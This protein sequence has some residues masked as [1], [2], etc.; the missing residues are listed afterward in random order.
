MT[1]GDHI[2]QDMAPLLRI[3]SLARRLDYYTGTVYEAALVDFPDDNSV[4]VVGRYKDLVGDFAKERIAGVDIS[5]GL[6]VTHNPSS[7]LDPPR[8]APCR[9]GSPPSAVVERRGPIQPNFSMRGRIVN[10]LL[11]AVADW[12]R[13]LGREA[14]TGNLQW[15]KVRLCRFGIPGSTPVP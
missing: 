5:L 13:Q 12:Q 14:E 11:N 2:C 9:L 10:S 7:S 15:E 6:T 8:S 1:I 4:A 3:C